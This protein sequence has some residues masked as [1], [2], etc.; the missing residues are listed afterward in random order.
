VQDDFRV[1]LR[2]EA[3]ARLLEL[4]AQLDEIVD[5]PVGNQNQFT[6]AGEKRL[7]PAAQV[8]NRQPRVGHA[9]RPVDVTVSMVRAAV[10]ERLYRRLKP[11]RID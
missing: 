8:D 11:G 9:E 7:I 6:V 5:F 4:S 10:A 2:A 3:M 1:G